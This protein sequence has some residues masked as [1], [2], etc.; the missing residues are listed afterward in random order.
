MFTGIIAHQ[1]ELFSVTTNAKQSQ[2]WIQSQFLDLV[3]GESIA[4]DGICLTVDE[5][6]GKNFLCALS[7]ETLR[8]TNARHY[9]KGRSVNL[10][11]A[12]QLQ[13][14]LGGHLVAGHVD[15]VA[16]VALIDQQ[17]DFT[18]ITFSHIAKTAMHYFVMKGSVCVNGVSLTLNRMTVDGFEVMLIPHTLHRTNLSYLKIN[19]E[20][21]IEF[22]Q[23]VKI[24]ERQLTCYK[25]ALCQ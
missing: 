4:V 12:L 24:I 1:G 25:E 5:I 11:R 16:R 15:C 9:Q 23:M 3:L 2:L 20:V 18:A 14:R 10:E 7:P 6:D 21:N 22:D 13:D 8:C 19:D 17:H